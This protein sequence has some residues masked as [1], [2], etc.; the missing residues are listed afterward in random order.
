MSNTNVIT[1]RPPADVMSQ[2]LQAKAATGADMTQLIVRCVRLSL[3]DAVAQILAERQKALFDFQQTVSLN[4]TP[5][6]YNTKP[7]K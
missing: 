1:L 6:R 5:V 3:A 4:E 7:K 2:L